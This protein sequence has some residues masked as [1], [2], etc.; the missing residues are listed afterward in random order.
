MRHLLLGNHGPFAFGFALRAAV[1]TP[2]KLPQ[3]QAWWDASDQS[4][5]TLNASRVAAIADKSSNA[6]TLT[7]PTASDQPI[8]DTSGAVASLPMLQQSIQDSLESTT[9]SLLRNTGDAYIFTVGYYPTTADSTSNYMLVFIS[10][11]TNAAS[12]RMGST[13]Y[14]TG[15]SNA[16]AVAGRRLDTDSYDVLP[17]ST[18]RASIENTLFIETSRRHYSQDKTYHWTNGNLD[19]NGVPFPNQTAGNT[20]DTNPL[21]V[22]LLAPSATLSTLPDTRIGEVIVCNQTL[23]EDDRQRVEGYLA[24]KWGGL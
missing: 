19:L 7:Q 6:Y 22:N 20:S 16:L 3:V 13:A 18:T 17:S 4:T 11:G 12:T 2:A 8:Y 10:S 24:W 23:T 5:I 14:P 1:W 15:G 21:L 9:T